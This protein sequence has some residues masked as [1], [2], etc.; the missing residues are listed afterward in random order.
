M[1]TMRFAASALAAGLVA[2]ALAVLGTSVAAQGAAVEP[3][4]VDGNPTCEDLGY[5]YGFKPGGEDLQKEPGEY[6]DGVVTVVW[7]YSNPPAMTSVDWSSSYPVAA[8]IVKAGSGANLYDYDPQLFSDT[9][10]ATPS[11]TGGVQAE[12]SHLVFC[13][14]VRP[15]VS[16]TADTSFDRA[17]AWTIDKDA[18]TTE[19]TLMAGQ[20]YDVNYEVDVARD[21]GTDSGWMVEGE[22]TIANPWPFV[23]TLVSVTDS[24]VTAGS[25]EVDCGGATTVPASDDLVCTY[26]APLT[27]GDAGTNTA[28]VETQYGDS[29]V[30]TSTGSKEFTFQ[31]PTTVTDEC[32]TVD[33]DLYGALGL[34]CATTTFPYT[35]TIGPYPEPGE[36]TVTN[37]ACFETDD[38]ATTGCDDHT[39]TVTVPETGVGCTLTQGYWK[40]H[41]Q[42]GPAP[43]DDD[44]ANLGPVQQSTQ[45]YLSG[46]TWYQ[47]FWTPP[48]GNAYYQL[49]HQF[50][51]AKL[52]V[53]NGASAPAEVTTAL[54]SADALFNSVG[55]TT[56]TRAQTTTARQLAAVLDAYNNGL[57]GPGHCSE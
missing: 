38:T 48:Q 44:W 50:M 1:K 23:L 32:I 7:S 35:M 10:L 37:T 49:A 31:D 40:T 26:S 6:T 20:S 45:F 3:E 9:G 25:G 36:Y 12:L 43:Y 24:L 55:G 4:F 28:T 22:I 39:V 46:K 19:L 27:S 57:T 18:D 41:S 30:R 11:N 13:Y 2:S 16:K 29:P 33:D 53:L 47:M 21:A 54:A 8:V 14:D 5:D 52:N 17:Y 34:T 15:F 56:L 42:F 51:A